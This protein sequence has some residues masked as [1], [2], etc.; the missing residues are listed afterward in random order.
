MA[1]DA[2][3]SVTF[4]A[5]PKTKKLIRRHGHAAGWGLICLFLWTAANRPDGD[6]EGMS[7]EDIELAVDWTGEEGALVKALKDVGFLDGDEGAY[8]IHDWA[9]HN[10]WAAGAKDRSD[11]SKFAALCKRYGRDKAADMMPDHAPRMRPAPDAHAPRTESAC[12]PDAETQIPQC[13]DTVTVSVSVTASDTDTVSNPPKPPKGGDAFSEDFQK[14]VEAYPERHGTKRLP[15]AWRAFNEALDRGATIGQLVTAAQAYG[16]TEAAGTRF[17]LQ[18]ANWLRSDEWKTPP[19]PPLEITDPE[20]NLWRAR[21]S[22]LKRGIP[23]KRDL[24]GP[25]PGELGCKV[26]A[27]L[28]PAEVFDPERDQPAFLKRT[29]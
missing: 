27:H 9:E 7:S 8:S 29:A 20:E 5:H 12:A 14:L 15:N 23:W 1:S 18:L 13:P 26:P 24:W 3:I 11:A 28:I 2:R 17:C 6:L 25:A 22:G 19:P 16:R 21:L 4:T 10:P